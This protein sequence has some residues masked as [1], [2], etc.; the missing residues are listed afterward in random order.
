M[1]SPTLLTRLD[2]IELSHNEYWTAPNLD[3]IG[4]TPVNRFWD[5]A[6]RGVTEAAEPRC[7]VEVGVASGLLTTKLLDY[8]EASGAVLHAIDPLPQIDIDEW[9]QRHGEHL[10]FHKALSL[11]AL[12]GI[13]DID[14]VFLDGDHN[15]FTVY[16]ELKLLEATSTQ[17][18][19]VPPLVALHDVDWPYGRRDL[20]YDPDSIPAAHR[21][22]YRKLGL[23]P[24]EAELVE[25]GL[26][27]DLNNAV[28][29]NS[30]HNGVR[31]ALEDF[32]AESEHEWELF[33]VPGFNG[34]GLAVT[35]DRL[36]KNE[37]LAR[38]LKSLRTARFLATWAQE[39][40]L[41]RVSLDAAWAFAEKGREQLTLELAD[42]RN[43]YAAQL[44]SE[45]DRAALEIANLEDRL[46][47]RDR[48]SELL[49]DAERRLASVPDLEVRIADLERELDEARTA[50]EDAHRHIQALDERLTRG[51]RVLT[52]VF[53]SPSWRLTKPLRS[54]KHILTRR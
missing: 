22:P 31:T 14:A 1:V 8:C 12:K 37:G 41:G 10:K 29:E 3:A 38:A 19:A 15:W 46:K 39:L 11:E 40:E 52:D 21:H 16:H 26:N 17:D 53:N 44:A 43:R 49:V 4:R 24:G 35:R 5:R 23:V 47:E 36:D 25:G 28:S 6:L 7:L 32:V 20:Y 30:A 42:E 34:L 54:T 27:S 9:R 50:A 45:R 48:L 13:H 2:P 18:G 51:Q 33:F